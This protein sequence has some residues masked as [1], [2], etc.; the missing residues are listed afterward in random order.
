MAG[1]TSQTDVYL[2]HTFTFSCS[3]VVGFVIDLVELLCEGQVVKDVVDSQRY[4]NVF[5]GDVL[6]AINDIT[7]RLW[8]HDDVVSLLRRCR[9]RRVATFTLMTSRDNNA[10]RDTAPPVRRP[11]AVPSRPVTAMASPLSADSQT[12]S[13]HVDY[14][15]LYRRMYSPVPFVRVSTEEATQKTSAAL[16]RPDA[17]FTHKVTS[18]GKPGV[19]QTSRYSAPPTPDI[20]DRSPAPRRVGP[21]G[22]RRDPRRSLPTQPAADVDLVSPLPPRR[23]SRES[24][25]TS[26][27]FSGTPD[28]VPASAYLD[29]D[30]R[31]RRAT[32]RPTV[33]HELAALTLND[34]AWSRGDEVFS[35]ST[36]NTPLLPTHLNDSFQSYGTDSASV[37][38]S[39]SLRNGLP[40]TSANTSGCHDRRTPAAFTGAGNESCNGYNARTEAVHSAAPVR[41]HPPSEQRQRSQSALADM[42]RPSRRSHRGSDIRL[43]V[44]SDHERPAVAVTAKSESVDHRDTKG[45]VA[46]NGVAEL[47]EPAPEPHTAQVVS[48][49]SSADDIL[50]LTS[51]LFEN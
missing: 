28:F 19:A 24:S 11:A 20:D 32:G 47:T 6:V 8:S 48:V 26:L 3:S 37:P 21:S 41:H 12:N 35:S 49:S 33:D 14:N 23:I 16:I 9:T 25:Q 27:N 22:R 46:L 43:S 17:T 31:R 30:D 4:R 10:W 42:I 5:P 7:V 13:P 38:S 51:T 40:V 2:I 34:P 39:G 50:L 18:N 1:L 45:S 29:D 15:Q 36:T 44:D